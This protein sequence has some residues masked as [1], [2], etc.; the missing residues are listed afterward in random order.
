MIR[1]L[2]TGGQGQLARA[3]A[4]AWGDADLR[5]LGREALDLGR[6]EQVRTAMEGLRPAVVINAA[7]F[8]AVDACQSSPEHAFRVNGHGVGQLAEACRAHGALLVQ[9]SS[10]YVFGGGG[11]R[12]LREGDEAAPATVYGQSK[13]L[14]ESE[15][16]RAPEHLILRSA[17]LFGGHGRNFLTTMRSLA[18]EGRPLRVVDDQRGSPTSHAALARQIRAS[19]R[20][21]HRGLM[22]ATC[23]G[24]ASWF[25]LARE[26]FRQTGL[27][28]ELVPVRSDE[29]PRPAP[30]PRYSVLD[31]HERLGLGA[32]VMGDWRE[33]LAEVV[34]TEL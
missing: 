27:D 34:R 30:R 15:A 26:I 24:E 18:R 32:D 4:A 29:L 10:D 5:L 8:T 28:P 1:V 22:H 12:P 11:A 23:A 25:E 33:A 17:W 3:L 7:A 19:V 20:A 16:R 2:V 14:G 6:P 31:N 13:W 9:I 21:G